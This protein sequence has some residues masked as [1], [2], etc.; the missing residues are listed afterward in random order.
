MEELGAQNRRGCPVSVFERWVLGRSL[1]PSDLGELAVADG[2]G[3]LSL[4]LAVAGTGE[5]EFVEEEVGEAGG[6][7]ADDAVLFEEVVAD[8]AHTELQEFVAVEAHGLGVLRAIA[9]RDVGGN[10]FGVGDDH[11]D[12]ATADMSLHG[13]KVFAERIMGGFAGLGHE[14]GDIYAWSFGAH[15]GVG[16][17]RDQQVGDDAGVERA[18]AHENEVGLLNGVDY[19][20]QGMDAA[21]TQF[22]FA[23]GDFAARDARFA[24]NALAVG[25]RGDEMHVGNGRRKNAAADSEDFGGD[26]N[27]FGKISGDVGE[28]G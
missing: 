3:G 27:G 25:E 1:P 21:G 16:D 26:T 13:G 18:R 23:N 19:A 7:V 12:N 9:A 6:I 2:F 28:R 5:E 15:D 11:V 17:F 8:D 24:M 20:G 22:D 14:I 4:K 10:R